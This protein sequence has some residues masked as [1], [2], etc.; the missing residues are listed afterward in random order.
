MGEVIRLGKRKWTVIFIEGEYG[1]SFRLVLVEVIRDMED[2]KSEVRYKWHVILVGTDLLFDRRDDS[3]E[4]F[5]KFYNYIEIFRRGRWY[6]DFCKF[7]IDCG[8]KDLI[9][10][11]VFN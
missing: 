11:I 8:R 2:K 6:N 4:D 7:L 1:V 10:R 9:D 5:V 3:L